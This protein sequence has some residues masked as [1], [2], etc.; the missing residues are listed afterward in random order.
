LTVTV[1]SAVTAGTISGIETFT[2]K[3]DA[4]GDTLALANVSG[5]TTLNLAENANGTSSDADVSGLNSGATVVIADADIDEVGVDTVANASIT[6]NLKETMTSGGANDGKITTSD[7]SSVTLTNTSSTAGVTVGL[8]LDS[9]DTTSL[10][11]NA[12]TA[13]DLTAGAITS[14][15][16]LTS[17]TFTA[18]TTGQDLAVTSLDDISSLTTLTVTAD[19]G[20][21]TFSGAIGAD[22]LNLS[23]DAL[24]TVNVSASNGATA[25]LVALYGDSV[26]DGTTADA[27]AADLAMTVT[28]TATGSNSVVELDTID[29]TYGTITI[30]TSGTGTV[31]SDASGSITADDITVTAGA[32]AGAFDLL[33]AT[34]DIVITATNSGALTFT[35]LDSGATSTGAITATASGS[36]AFEITGVVASA[37]ALT[38]N[39]SSA[40]GTVKVDGSN[41]T[42]VASLTGGTANDTLVGGSGNDV[43]TGNAG[44]DSL[45]GGAGNDVLTGGAGDDTLIL[46][47]TGNDSL[48]GG[49]GDDTFVVVASTDTVTSA[50]TLDGGTG[51]DTL[52]F[53]VS[54]STVSPTLTSIETL[55][56]TFASAAGGAL[57]LGNASSAT[58]VKLLSD[59][60]STTATVINMASGTTVNVGDANTDTVTL[61]TATGASLTVKYSA[62]LG[63]ST[64]ISDAVS[65][66]VVSGTA[67]GDAVAMAFDDTDT[68]TIT[69]AATTKDVDTGALTGTSNVT[70]LTVS[71]TTSGNTAAVDTVAEA[72]NLETLTVT[73]VGANASVSTVGSGGTEADELATINITATSANAT[74][75]AVTA[76]TA[77]NDA[78]DL[79]MTVTMSAAS[80]RT[81]QIG[82]IDNEYGTVTFNLSGA[83][84]ITAGAVT[85]AD[86]TVN[87]GSTSGV[88]TLDMSSVA[89]GVSA[90]LGTGTNSYTAGLSSDTI[91]LAAASGTDVITLNGA[92]G[93]V[94]ITNFQTDGV[95]QIEIDLSRVS[96]PIDGNNAAILAATASAIEEVSA[97]ET[98]TTGDTIIVLTGTQFATSA[99]AETAIEGGTHA[100]TLQA[101]STSGDDIFVVW[102]DGTNSYLG[103][104]NITSTTAA[105]TAGSMTVLATLVGVD[106]SVA[107]TLTAA[108]FD[109]VS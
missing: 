73:A 38:V 105:I 79:A 83:G 10:T 52:T 92:S 87:A 13:A 37:G 109:F 95:D 24:A 81:A 12:G 67:D 88:V 55:N 68:T 97:A 22:T 84:T 90:T 44:D 17:A 56:A 19:A 101:S 91:T 47:G 42:G 43:L 33:T 30:V 40:T 104:Y 77:S 45:T 31:G 89:A 107:G 66:S 59:N 61:D 32:A 36:G 7:A 39:G 74:V 29:N 21:V 34:D 25:T 71:T 15:G 28:A 6:Y 72:E 5:I 3:F 108:N 62:V 54:T 64:S 70:S 103:A 49:D 26:T 98:L 1:T 76:D 69:V 102:S 58:T 106:A 93:S 46:G 63:G 86:A 75:G 4:D 100:L 51:N 96:A 20:N 48:S 9:T 41:W 94:E 23:G 60:N 82:A 11:I 85:A 53:T 80:S 8:A 65:V 99:L 78:S 16:A 2:A 27:T 14:A 18:Q 50:D 57:N 35:S